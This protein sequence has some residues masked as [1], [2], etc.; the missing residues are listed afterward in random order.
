MVLLASPGDPVHSERPAFGRVTD[1]PGA[2]Q[3]EC[4]AGGS[5]VGRNG[6]DDADVVVVAGCGVPAAAAGRQEQALGTGE[7]VEVL[8]RDELRVR[9]G[10]ADRPPHL[11]DAVRARRAVVLA[12]LDQLPGGDP[13]GEVLLEDRRPVAIGVTVDENRPGAGAGTRPRGI[14]RTCLALEGRKPLTRRRM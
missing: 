12:Q 9:V 1:V 2:G 11:R 5:R 10:R 6:E 3:P 13:A 4:R 7:V 14:P 8:A